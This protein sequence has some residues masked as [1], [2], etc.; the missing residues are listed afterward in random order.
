VIF[1]DAVL[2]FTHIAEIILIATVVSTLMKKLKQ[3][4]L[5][6]YIIAGIV[7]GPMV[8]G[9][10]NLE[11]FGFPFNIG[12]SKVT[13]EIELL[14]ILG[15]SFL[16]FS[17][18]IETSLHRLLKVG[19]QVI[20]AT[21]LQVL[22][23]IVSTFILTVPTGLLNFEQALFVG[24]II[25]FSSTM[26]VVKILSDSGEINS[27]QGRLMISILLLQDLLVIFVVPILTNIS[28]IGDVMLLVSLVGK[29]LF[30][31]LVAFVLNK[32]VFPKLFRVA[33]EE[34]ELFLL[35]SIATAFVFIGLAV[36]LKM[37]EPVGA[38]IGGLALS[39]LPYNLEI[40]SKIRALRDFF[41]VIFF[42]SLGIQLSF[43]FSSLNILLMV[44]IFALVFVIK[45]IIF[46]CISLL[47]GYGS[48]TGVKLGLSL[49]SV[50]EFG[51]EITSVAGLTIMASGAF[52][53]S[54][55]FAS[56]IVAVIALSMIVSPYFMHSSSRVAN[57][58]YGI[59]KNLPKGFRRDFFKRKIEELERIPSKRALMDHIIIVG[60][61]TIGRGLAKQLVRENQVIVV[62][63][64]PEVV[65]QGQI[66]NLPYV[67]GT[68]EN[69][70]LW[71][72]LDLNDAKLL[73]ITV[74]N[75]AEALNIVRQ[76]KRSCPKLKIF[77]IAHYFSDTLS[78][79]ESG[80]D[81]VAM[82]SVMGSNIFLQNIYDYIQTGKVSSVQNFKGMYIDYLKNQIEEEKK[83]R[84]A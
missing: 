46:F 28:Q 60:G 23:V 26:I 73:V 35:S 70:N 7:L 33:A 66:D 19:N 74:L 16:L 27:L 36:L 81:F 71:D 5:F 64:D 80:V 69:E 47:L 4:S 67:Y 57:Y 54:K 29:S 51:F 56:F 53:F 30:L 48:K 76:A 1:L 84:K 65:E 18:G 72:K 39:T 24:A 45:P 9:S 8:L 79:Y 38:F 62:D 59:V 17:I 49:S 63:Y 44:A 58:F 50:S 32:F 42:V 68:S 41:L 20:L 14:S 37:P 55:D 40:F 15:A 83:Y 25:S 61:G 34:Q 6:A 13:E 3:P 77:C 2:L 22:L 43:G 21:V 11:A 78:F 52:V 12:I 10:I 75:H 82:P 31:V